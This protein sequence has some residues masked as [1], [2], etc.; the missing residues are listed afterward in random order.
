MKAMFCLIILIL[1]F[2]MAYPRR[3]SNEFEN[4]LEMYLNKRAEQLDAMNQ[5][6]SDEEFIDRRHNE[7]SEHEERQSSVDCIPNLWTCGPSLP[8]CCSGYM[9][10][11]GNAK[12]G[13][14]CVA[15]G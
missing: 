5:S 15:R 11:D 14:H 7:L 1:P 9:C 10:F 6:D 4:L 13:R 8:P 12:R 2:T 3:L